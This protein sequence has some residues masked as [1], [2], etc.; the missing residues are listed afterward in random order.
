VEKND[1]LL[2]QMLEDVEWQEEVKKM[3]ELFECL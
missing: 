1:F 2:N 3:K